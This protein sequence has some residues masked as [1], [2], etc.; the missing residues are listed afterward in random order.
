MDVETTG[1]DHRRDEVIEIGM[2]AF[3]HDAAGRVGP[4]IGAINALREPSVEI[5]LAITKLTGITPEMVAGQ[6]LDLDTVRALLE[7]ADL[8]IAHNA[9]I[10]PQLM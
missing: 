10:R 4:V 6:V 7:T 9:K 3:V 5:T 8:M 1:L 2:V